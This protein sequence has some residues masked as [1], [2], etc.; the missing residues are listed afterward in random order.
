MPDPKDGDV[1]GEDAPRL[2]IYRH[3]HPHGR[4]APM[5]AP[6]PPHDHDHTHSTALDHHHPDE[7][8]E[9]GLRNATPEP[10]ERFR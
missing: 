2:R 3:R 8:Y 5:F 4:H 7:H 9:H 10:D 6:E 1:P